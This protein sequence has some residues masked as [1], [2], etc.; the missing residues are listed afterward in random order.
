VGA[1][2]YGA[3]WTFRAYL[4]W[5]AFGR[6]RDRD[7]MVLNLD[8]FDERRQLE[9]G[10]WDQSFI[11]FNSSDQRRESELLFPLATERPATLLHEN[12]PVPF[13]GGRHAITLEPG[14]A[15]WLRLMIQRSDNT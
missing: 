5:E 11:A 2:I 6:A 3:G 12:K 14:E 4:L 10:K 13:A 9:A 15:K 1:E 7:I 8:S